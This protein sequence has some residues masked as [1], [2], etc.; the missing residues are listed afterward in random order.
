MANQGKEGGKEWRYKSKACFTHPLAL[1]FALLFN[2]LH[3]PYLSI[4]KGG[5]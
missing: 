2:R 4:T 5:S 1:A 3:L